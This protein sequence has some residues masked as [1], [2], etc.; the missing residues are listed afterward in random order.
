MPRL[1]L[2]CYDGVTSMKAFRLPAVLAACALAALLHHAP[3][4]AARM[5]DPCE[6][7]NVERIVAVGDVHGA[8]D[9]L[10]EILRT[11]GLIDKDNRWAGGR[12]HLV[13]TGDIFDRGPDSLKAMEFLRKLTREADRAGGR[14][15]ALLGNHEVMRL[16]AQFRDAHPG[17]YEAFRNAGSADLRERVASQYDPAT[18]AKI[19]AEPLGMI[20]MIDAF[21]PQAN[22]GA[23]LRTLNTAVR[24][25]GVVFV[26]GGLNPEVAKM[27]CAQINDGVRREI[28]RDYAKTLKAPEKTLSAGEFGPLWYRGL[29]IEPDEFAPQV[30]AILAAQKARAIVVGHSISQGKIASRFGQRVFLI[31]TG[32]Q[33]GYVPGGQPAA[34]E[35]K[36]P[37]FTAIYMDRRAVLAGG[38]AEGVIR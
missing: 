33:R 8:H 11:A 17:E 10:L 27:S 21:K 24:I 34:L 6:F 22:H 38:A 9:A 1:G 5:A 37:T 25:N 29:A 12:A 32:M 19:L 14:V 18:R 13:Q 15:H 20:E 4:T 7:E 26:H 16:L 30:D 28:G 31:D 2:F 35:I 36:G 3:I 23:Y